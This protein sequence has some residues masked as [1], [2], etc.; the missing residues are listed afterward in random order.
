MMMIVFFVLAAC[1][2]AAVAPPFRVP[3]IENCGSPLIDVDHMAV[4]R[5]EKNSFLAFVKGTAAISFLNGNAGD[6]RPPLM[7]RSLTSTKE[8]QAMVHFGAGCGSP[9]RVLPLPQRLGNV[10]VLCPCYVPLGQEVSCSFYIMLDAA[11]RPAAQLNLTFSTQE[12]LCA[13]VSIY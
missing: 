3:E 6:Y 4:V 9:S 2:A 11:T 10:S 13:H 1:A 8:E 5:T 12:F 7:I